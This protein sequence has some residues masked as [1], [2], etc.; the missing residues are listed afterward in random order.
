MKVI[1]VI[2]SP[3]SGKTWVCEQLKSKYTHLP[4]DDYINKDYVKAI[5]D[6]KSDKNLLIEIPFSMSKILDPLKA[7][8]LLVTTVFVIESLDTLKQRY[9]EREGKEIHKGHLTRQATFE[10]RADESK[11][12]KGTAAQ[13]LK[14][15][16]D[17]L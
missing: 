11:S 12:F 6:T 9:L 8:N 1:A 17:L 7:A 15:L 4:H 5:L 10:K 2:G 13:V 16:K 14:H 3:G